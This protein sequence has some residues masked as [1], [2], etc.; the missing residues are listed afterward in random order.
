MNLQR[1]FQQSY[2]KRLI[3]IEQLRTLRDQEETDAE[4]RSRLN[5]KIK[6]EKRQLDVINEVWNVI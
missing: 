3:H 5:K 1:H 2:N 4:T 6:Y